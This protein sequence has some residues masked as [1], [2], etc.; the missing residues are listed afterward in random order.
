MLGFLVID[1]PVDWTSHDVVGK[2]RRILRTKRIGHAGTLD[3]LATGVLVV[4]V[5]PATRMLQYLPLEPKVYE[6]TVRFGVSTTTFDAE[7]EVI[8]ERPVPAD[9]PAQI[10]AQLPRFRGEIQQLP[11]MYSAVKKQGKPLYAYAR[12]GVSVEREPR[13]VTVSALEA[14][15]IEGTDVSFRIECSG[16]TYIRTLAH[17]LGEEIGCGAHVVAL[18]RTRVGDFLE[19]VAIPLEEVGAEKLISLRDAL[20]SLPQ[21]SLTEQETRDIRQ[22]RPIPARTNGHEIVLSD[23]AGNVV[24][25]GRADAIQIHPI[26]VMRTE[27]DGLV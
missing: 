27:T 24:A 25:I 21:Y 4:A 2:L 18:R 3:P 9:L 1:K 14:L 16:G 19:G 22:G 15:E 26:C 7:G 6:V 5:G 11:P 12:Q 8:Q 13:R 20:R 10:E 23:S 17:D